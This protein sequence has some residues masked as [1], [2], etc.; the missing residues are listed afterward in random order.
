M[1]RLGQEQIGTRPGTVTWCGNDAKNGQDEDPP[2]A[3][4]TRS[5]FLASCSTGSDERQ[6]IPGQHD[7]KNDLQFIDG[8]FHTRGTTSN[9]VFEKHHRLE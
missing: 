3:V 6:H 2:G 5:R 9:N 4:K 7:P 1:Q 8:A